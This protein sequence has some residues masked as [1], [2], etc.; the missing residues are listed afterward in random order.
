MQALSAEQ[1]SCQSMHTQIDSTDAERL[2]MAPEQ[3]LLLLLSSS[4]PLPWLLHHRV[5]ARADIR[6]LRVWP[7]E[8]RRRVQRSQSRQATAGE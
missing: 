1:R 2:L 5:G 7:E 8:K 4:P 3:L 6:L